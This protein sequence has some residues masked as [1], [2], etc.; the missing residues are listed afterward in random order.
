[1]VVICNCRGI[2][3]KKDEMIRM[4]ILKL[5]EMTSDRDEWRDQHENLL[6]IYRAELAKRQQPVKQ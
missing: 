4:L 6:A 1:M 5:A 3:A 2:I